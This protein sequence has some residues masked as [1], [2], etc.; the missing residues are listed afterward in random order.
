MINNK[1]RE[2]RIIIRVISDYL[3]SEKTH[4]SGQTKDSPRDSGELAVLL[5]VADGG[6]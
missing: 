5:N 4:Y 1:L 3:L 2:I 6:F